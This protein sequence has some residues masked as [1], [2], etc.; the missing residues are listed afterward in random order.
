MS[1]KANEFTFQ[2]EKYTLEAE[3]PKDLRAVLQQLRKWKA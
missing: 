3:V 1:S 2:N